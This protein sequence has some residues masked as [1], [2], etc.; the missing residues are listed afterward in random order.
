MEIALPQNVAPGQE[1][2]LDAIH[3]DDDMDETRSIIWVQ[4][5]R[6]QW[7]CPVESYIVGDCKCTWG[8]A[9][10]LDEDI[11]ALDMAANIIS[12]LSQTNLLRCTQCTATP[13]RER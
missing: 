1:R 3:V 4:C 12:G 2:L 5:R 13:Q 6:C 10:E 8:P 11:Q 9:E 7:S